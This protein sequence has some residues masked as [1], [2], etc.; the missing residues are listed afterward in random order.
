[1]IIIKQ[2]PTDHIRTF[3]LCSSTKPQK[4]DI[5]SNG[6]ASNSSIWMT[7]ISSYNRVKFFTFPFARSEIHIS[8]PHQKK[9]KEDLLPLACILHF[10]KSVAFYS[11]RYPTVHLKRKRDIHI[12]RNTCIFPYVHMMNFIA[13]S[14]R[15]A[16][17]SAKKILGHIFDGEIAFGG[18]IRSPR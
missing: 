14:I 9:R 13:A 6:L 17:G 3:W 2:Y 16:E 15:V 7:H 12:F 10:S 1:M 8:F 18:Q 11:S 5:R 4:H